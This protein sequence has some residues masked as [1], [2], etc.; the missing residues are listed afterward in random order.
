MRVALGAWVAVVRLA[1]RIVVEEGMLKLYGRGGLRI[2]LLELGSR[3]SGLA[4]VWQVRRRA[5]SKE[6][7]LRR[8]CMAG[9]MR[10]IVGVL[11]F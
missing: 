4:V 3:A 1:V 5:G 10:R 7:G 6:Y 11:L 8:G 9:L 2:R